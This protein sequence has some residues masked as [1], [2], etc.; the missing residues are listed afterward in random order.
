[1]SSPQVFV[2]NRKIAYRLVKKAKNKLKKI[3]DASKHILTQNETTEDKKAKILANK[4]D[5]NAKR[6]N[7]A[8]NIVHN[9]T[10]S[11]AEDA[12]GEF[13]MIGLFSKKA[14]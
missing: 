4:R 3:L 2:I 13:R 14:G 8:F 12:S 5:I 6:I 11:T 1:M 10:N 9:N 7:R